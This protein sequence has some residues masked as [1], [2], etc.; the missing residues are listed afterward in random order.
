MKIRE[1]REK[2]ENELRKDLTGLRNKMAKLRFDISAKQVKNHRE[3]RKTK[4]DIARI[5]TVLK[6]QK[7]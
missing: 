7:A 1:I 4:Q 2:S 5:L 6:S 3:I